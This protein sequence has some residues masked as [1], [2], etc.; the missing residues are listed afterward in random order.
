MSFDELIRN[1]RAEFTKNFR[2]LCRQAM[3]SVIVSVNCE[4]VL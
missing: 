4:L 3:T 1:R 2:R